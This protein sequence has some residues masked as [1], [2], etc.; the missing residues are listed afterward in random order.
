[1]EKGVIKILKRSCRSRQLVVGLFLCS[2]LSLLHRWAER[3]RS[4]RKELGEPSE[5]LTLKQE[6]AL[7]GKKR[8]KANKLQRKMMSDLQGLVKL[9]LKYPEQLMMAKLVSAISW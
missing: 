1:M 6:E 2:G 9:G 5:F 4:V 8:C 7:I 3:K